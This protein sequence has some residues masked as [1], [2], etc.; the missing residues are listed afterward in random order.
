MGLGR[1]SGS[2]MG[3]RIQQRSNPGPFDLESVTRATALFDLRRRLP[4]RC[5]AQQSD[6]HEE[7]AVPEAGT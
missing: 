5:R 2:G 7:Q 1:V 6:S 4:P 3:R